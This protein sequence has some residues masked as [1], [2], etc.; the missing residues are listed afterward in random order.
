MSKPESVT[1]LRLFLWFGRPVICACLTRTRRIS[2]IVEGEAAPV[3]CAATFCNARAFSQVQSCPGLHCPVFDHT[4]E[5][6][7][8][9]LN[10]SVTKTLFSSRYR[11]LKVRIFAFYQHVSKTPK[12]SY[13]KLDDNMG[14]AKL[15]YTI[16]LQLRKYA[17]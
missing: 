1:G 6:R 9:H 13:A 14:K 4:I 11:T 16:S 12:E 10:Q 3:F 17:D 5:D 2:F 7:E 15:R 8:L